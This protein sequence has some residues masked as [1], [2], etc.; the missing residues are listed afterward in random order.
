MKYILFLLLAF[1]ICP[2]TVKSNTNNCVTEG[3]FIG[4]SEAIKCLEEAKKEN[5]NLKI[6][7][8]KSS[9]SLN[10]IVSDNITI[11]TMNK[12]QELHNVA[13]DK[14]QQSFS[15]F[16]TMVIIINGI[17]AV[18]VGCL[19]LINFKYVSHSKNNLKNLERD[20]KNKI[21]TL[22][23]ELEGQIK[24][25]KIKFTDLGQEQEQGR[26]QKKNRNWLYICFVAS[27]VVICLII[28]F[29]MPPIF[30]S[31]S[32][33]NLSSTSRIIFSIASVLIM[34]CFYLWMEKEIT[35]IITVRNVVNKLTLSELKI[36]NDY[37]FL[38]G[39]KAV[40]LD[41][42]DEISAEVC[43]LEAADIIYKSIK[44]TGGG[45][46]ARYLYS[47]NPTY[48]KNLYERVKKKLP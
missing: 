26:K 13:F 40:K 36:V 18:F 17:L 14:M 16:L 39:K 37:F 24:N 1:S 27:L 35:K 38:S 29:A 5:N 21:M 31:E 30:L 45:E 10:K 41:G 48:E 32:F 3:R 22:K 33:R 28:L 8:K 46:D 9:E 25:Q 43:S 4:Y 20:F 7:I 19:I 15:N 6:E 23:T 42:I 11:E 2:A 47:I 44:Q 12:M 34:I